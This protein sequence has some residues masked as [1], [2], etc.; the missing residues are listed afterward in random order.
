MIL[1]TMMHYHAE[2]V[3][4]FIKLFIL[5]VFDQKG[6]AVEALYCTSH[7]SGPCQIIEMC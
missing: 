2:K 7:P 6:F 5:W 3:H 1:L 4:N